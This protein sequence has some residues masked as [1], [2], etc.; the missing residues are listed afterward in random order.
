MSKKL[1]LLVATVTVISGCSSLGGLKGGPARDS[2]SRSVFTQSSASDKWIYEKGSV[3]TPDGTKYLADGSK[4]IRDNSAKSPASKPEQTEPCKQKHGFNTSSYFLCKAEL[5]KEQEKAKKLAEL[6]DD[7]VCKG[8]GLKLNS[9]EYFQCRAELAELTSVPETKDK[10]Q[11]QSVTTHLKETDSVLSG[12]TSPNRQF[13]ESLGDENLIN[14]LI[15]NVSYQDKPLLILSR[16]GDFMTKGRVEVE[17]DG[18]T[19]EIFFGVATIFELNKGKYQLKIKTYGLLCSKEI[20]EAVEIGDQQISVMLIGLLRRGFC[21][22]GSY[23][24][25]ERYSAD[26]VLLNRIKLEAS[27]DQSVGIHK[28]LQTARSK[29][30]DMEAKITSLVNRHRSIPAQKIAVDT[31][32]ANQPVTTRIFDYK[33]MNPIDGKT[34]R[35]GINAE[36]YFFEHETG[37][38]EVNFY[39]HRIEPGL[40][41]QMLPALQM[42][43]GHPCKRVLFDITSNGGSVTDS[44]LLGLYV[45]KS[46]WDT[47]YGMVQG[48]VPLSFRVCFSSCA[49][50]FLAGVR[51]YAHMATSPVNFLI[52]EET[53]KPTYLLGLH[54]PARYADGRKICVSDENSE[55]AG[56]MRE[57]FVYMLPTVGYNIHQEVMHIS[58]NGLD[59]LA[60]PHKLGIITGER[61]IVRHKL[62]DGFD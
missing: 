24:P 32:D 50:V 47:G 26:K 53:Y 62:Q 19:K 17:I 48:L 27:D 57:Y 18:Q 22:V 36:I 35:W 9:R 51:R 10:G 2:S 56:I 34:S 28:A 46:G 42:I 25:F 60:L 61:S 16:T 15:R 4:I 14:P 33:Q 7:E 54:Q 31:N 3:T 52:S 11:S 1:T 13:K 37:L 40:F 30:R 55:I 5:A 39:T 59:S 29:F 21:D 12:E 58:C 20:K 41:E 45:R 23:F 6:D 43:Q 44:F 8:R 49:N 38:C